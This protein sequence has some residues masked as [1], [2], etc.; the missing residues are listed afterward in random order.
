MTVLPGGGIELDHITD[1]DDSV[2]MAQWGGRAPGLWHWQARRRPG[3]VA[4]QIEPRS[5]ESPSRLR[6][7]LC[8]SELEMTM[9]VSRTRDHNREFKFSSES[10]AI[11]Y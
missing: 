4:P 1:D 5:Y 8:G 9:P 7:R 6:L 10:N 3:A 2:I 11:Y